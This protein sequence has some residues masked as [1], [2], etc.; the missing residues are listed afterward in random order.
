MAMVRFDARRRCSEG[1]RVRVRLGSC[2]GLLCVDRPWCARTYRR[3]SAGCRILHRWP[4]GRACDEMV[5][6]PSFPGWLPA[7]P[8]L[9]HDGSDQER[10]PRIGSCAPAPPRRAKDVL[11]I[12][13]APLKLKNIKEPLGQSGI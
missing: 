6:S 4:R 3:E 8:V 9:A 5:D 1:V 12:D 7:F 11:S 13:G 2:S 10:S